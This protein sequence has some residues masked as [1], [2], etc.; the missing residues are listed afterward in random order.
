MYRIGSYIMASNFNFG[1]L[2]EFV[3]FQHNKQNWCQPAGQM[4]NFLTEHGLSWQLSSRDLPREMKLLLQK[5]LILPMLLYGSEAWRLLRSDAAALGVF[6]GKI[7]LKI[8]YLLY[9]DDDISIWTFKEL[10]ELLNVVDGAWS[11]NIK[12]LC[13]LSFVVRMEE[14]VPA[15]Q[16]FF[17]LE[18]TGVVARIK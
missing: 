8:L 11:I 17:F 7:L 13:W 10:Y 15:G 4:Q 1:F 9:V 5:S 2:D 14:H 18:W 3:Y 16:V 6:V 12:R